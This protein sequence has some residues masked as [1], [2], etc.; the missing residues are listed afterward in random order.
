M[1]LPYH[2]G[3]AARRE[4]KRANAPKR[5]VSLAPINGYRQPGGRHRAPF[6]PIFA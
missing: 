3:W 1:C 2:R 6:A 4:N 5:D